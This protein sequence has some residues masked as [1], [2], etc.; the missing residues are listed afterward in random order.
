MS[1]EPAHHPEENPYE[2]PAA[3]SPAVGVIGGSREDLYNVARYQRGI[4]FCI[5]IQLGVLFGA[6]VLPAELQLLAELGLLAA[7]VAGAVFVFL[8]AIKV[9]GAGLGV[10]LGV[11]ALVP[12]LGLLIL[13]IV[14]GKGTRVLRDNGIRVAGFASHQPRKRLITPRLLCSGEP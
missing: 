13:L 11:L 12:L 10:L 7:G 3:G 2:A 1:E 4:I 5:L 9:Y 14:N 6:A 8:L